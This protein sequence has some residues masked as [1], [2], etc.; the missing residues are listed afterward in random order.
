MPELYLFTL[1]NIYNVVFLQ[2]RW[3]IIDF[4]E[5]YFYCLIV[6]LRLGPYYQKA[7]KEEF[8]SKPKGAPFGKF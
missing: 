5:V 3:S 1:L 2:K 8:D 7:T 6:W 4:T